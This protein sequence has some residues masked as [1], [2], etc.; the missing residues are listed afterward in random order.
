MLKEVLSEIKPTKKEEA[1][2][3]R[4]TTSFLKKLN[5]KLKDAKAIIGG[6][7][8]KGTWLKGAHDVDI[9]VVFNY[10]KFSTKSSELSDILDP[11][12][13]KCFPKHKRVHGSRDYFQITYQN[14]DFEVVPILNISKAEQAKNITDISPLHVK[15]VKKQKR[16]DDMR[17]AK[18]FARAIGVY[19]AESYISGFSG[20][21]LEILIGYY[22]SFEKFLKAASSWESG[23][24]IDVENY[25]KK[26]K[27]M[28]E[29]NQSKL[30]SPITVI[31]PVDKSRNAAAALSAEKFTFLRTAANEF[32]KN[33]RKEIFTKER[34]SF[35]ELKKLNTNIV[36][37]EIQPL[38]GKRDVVGSKLLKAFEFMKKE[39]NEFGL[40]DSGWEF[41]GKALVYFSLQ[42][43]LLE[44]SFV[45]EGPPTKLDHATQNFKR[46]N[47]DTFVKGKRI[48][49][50]IQRKHVEL[51]KAVIALVK[52]KYVTERVKKI[53]ITL[54]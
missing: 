47:K 51:K 42:R 25:Y 22:G 50:N 21:V 43:K 37:L 54:L 24:I 13:K 15:W 32:V 26:K 38:S 10:K 30:Q 36:Y 18:H 9:F 12:M 6:S 46:K 35:K 14:F 33:P 11:V 3:K 53:K 45:R 29:L 40:L 8:A 27:V 44:P 20:Y 49:A 16:N 41:D 1:D 17:L 5:A 52:E 19:G 39:L 7:G 2:F 31:D 28:L 34:I 23:L 48:Y 4:V